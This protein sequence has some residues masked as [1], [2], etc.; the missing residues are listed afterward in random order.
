MGNQ[1]LID[2]LGRHREIVEESARK[3]LAKQRKEAEQKKIKNLEKFINSFVQDAELFEVDAFDE[4]DASTQQKYS[5][6][7]HENI[8]KLTS[9][10]RIP[11][12]ITLKSLEDYAERVTKI[13]DELNEIFRKYVKLLDRTF[14]SKVRTL[15]KSYKR[16]YKEYLGFRKFIEKKYKPKA[17]IESS[18]WEIDEIIPLVENYE[19]LATKVLGLEGDVKSKRVKIEQT[20]AELAELESHEAKVKYDDAVKEFSKFQK[21]FDDT[22]Y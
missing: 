17:N 4:K 16:I 10:P 6:R 8:I 22:F 15:D 13:L 1:A 7:M 21:K 11:K 14:T 19:I 3:E 18:I 9:A 12:R 20:E 5:K 2:E